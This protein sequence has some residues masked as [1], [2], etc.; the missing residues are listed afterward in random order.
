MQTSSVS[1]DGERMRAFGRELDRIK[2]E[3]TGRMGDEDV[4][5]VKRLD[6]LSHVCEVIGRVLI[7]V[8]FEPLSFGIGVV[9]LWIHKQLQATEIGHTALHGAYDDLPGAERYRSK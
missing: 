3:V 4:R 8:S 9:A 6:R 2:A 7:H 5:Y 1:D